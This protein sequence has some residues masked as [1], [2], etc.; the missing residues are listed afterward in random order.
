MAKPELCMWPDMQAA[1]AGDDRRQIRDKEIRTRLAKNFIG[2]HH[3]VKW[4]C[5][6][7]AITVN[8]C[9]G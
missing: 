3:P 1:Y 2:H 8:C 7:T 6:V 5:H 9:A 4:P